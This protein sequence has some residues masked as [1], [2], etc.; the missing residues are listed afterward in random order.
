MFRP[1]PTTP[2]EPLFHVRQPGNNNRNVDRHAAFAYEGIQRLDN[3]TTHRSNVFAVW[4]TT[5]YFEVTKNP[6]SLINENGVDSGH[7]D[8][9]QIGKELGSDT[10][11]IKRHRAFYIIDRSIPV[12]FEI[13]KNHNVDDTI[14]LRR[15]IE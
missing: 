10:G 9:Y 11:E 1:R 8:G 5:G 15:I 3:L 6:P 7:L 4:I 14:L 13:G 12:G 2:D